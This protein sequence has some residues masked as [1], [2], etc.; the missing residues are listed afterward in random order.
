MASCA[1]IAELAQAYLDDELKHADRVILE[2][3]VSDCGACATELRRRQ[4]VSAALFESLGEHRLNESLR[5]KVMDHLPEMEP[6]PADL[7]GLNWRTKHPVPAWHRAARW[8]P[9]AAL[10]IVV[11]LALILHFNWPEPVVDWG[12]VGLVDHTGGRV[13]CVND[14]DTGRHPVKQRDLVRSGTWYETGEK[15]T[16][17]FSLIGMT[18]LSLRAGSRIR[19]ADAR[20]IKV[21]K[22]TVWL[23]IGRDGRVFRITTPSGVVT[24]FG[25][26]LKVSVTGDDTMV[27]VADGEVTVEA[28]DHFRVVQ[29]GYEMHIPANGTPYEPRPVAVEPLL[30]WAQSVKPDGPNAERLR[31]IKAQAGAYLRQPALHSYLVDLAGKDTVTAIGFDWEPGPYA[32]EYCSYDIYVSDAAMTPLFKGR[33]DGALFADPE[34]RSHEVL[35]PG[36]PIT[37]VRALF[38]RLVPDFSTGTPEPLNL[39]V[40]AKAVGETGTKT[41]S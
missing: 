34:R 27:S 15:S 7:K 35:V 40:K 3:H 14:D 16:A 21:Q 23:D 38:I 41:A 24:V 31:E 33:L 8:L 25:T 29:P 13:Q 19:I 17:V 1:K 28:G 30:A 9:A 10:A 12:S 4:Q 2:Q 22:G 5:E 20:R 6:S 32:G 18:R 36:K 11:L 37:D 26:V 39:S